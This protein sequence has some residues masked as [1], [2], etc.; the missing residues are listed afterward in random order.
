MKNQVSTI[1][2]PVSTL[3]AIKN[4]LFSEKEGGV[5]LSPIVTDLTVGGANSDLVAINVGLTFKGIK[6]DID[7]TTRYTRDY[8]ELVE[9]TFVSYSMIRDLVTYERKT[10]AKW[11]SA[12]NDLCPCSN[13]GYL[14]SCSLS[15][16]LDKS[17]DRS[18]PTHELVMTW[19]K[20]EEDKPQPST[21]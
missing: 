10:I 13:E 11:D 9:Y 19:A 4:L 18:I 1:N 3:N 20:K 15:A 16:W 17:T 7:K 14:D 8:K 12:K 2:V 5:D 6:P 21:L